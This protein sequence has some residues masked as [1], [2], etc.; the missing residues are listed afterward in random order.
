VTELGV[1]FMVVVIVSCVTALIATAIRRGA[2]IRRRPVTSSVALTGLVLFSSDGCAAC[3]QLSDHLAAAGV[4]GVTVLDWIESPEPFLEN[5]IDRVP[6][7]MALDDDGHGW[8]VQG[9]PSVA[10][11]RKWLG[12]P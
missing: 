10:R 8:M 12:G 11:L 5:H 2:V 4:D 3:R 9:V 6:T 7:L 1:R